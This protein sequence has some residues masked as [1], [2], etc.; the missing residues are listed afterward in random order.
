MA[1]EREEGTRLMEE[2]LRSWTTLGDLWGVGLTH[3]TLG[4]VADMA[5]E[6]AAAVAHYTDG[7]RE[8]EAA[9]DAHQAAYYHGFLGVNA[10]KLGDLHRAAG[11]CAC[12]IAN[13]RRLPRSLAPQY[14]CA[15]DVG[16]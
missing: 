14:G 9:G 13:E 15:S 8:L 4:L 3:C 11:A 5:G 6:T 7:V 12:G 16:P 10:W 2:A 1:G